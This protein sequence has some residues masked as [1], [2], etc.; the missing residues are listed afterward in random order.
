MHTWTVA[1]RQRVFEEFYQLTAREV[2]DATFARTAFLPPHCAISKALE[3]LVTADHAWIH[4]ENDVDRR[5]ESILVREDLLRAL[6]PPHASYTR[7]SSTR[8]HSLA[9]GSADCVCRFT[10]G[11]VLHRVAP[12][13][14]CREILRLME[15]KGARY[16]PVVE[17]GL[18]IG[19]IGA[20]D[21]LRTMR[22]LDAREAQAP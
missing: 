19:E 22:R 9:H 13:S 14:T 12:D 6:G 1:T 5:V 20:I 4:A 8:A 3:A 18:L 10:E 7:F 16:L 11:R 21:V 15:G 2:M 17:D